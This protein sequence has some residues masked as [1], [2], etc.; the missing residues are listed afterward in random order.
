MRWNAHIEIGDP[1][2]LLY[3]DSIGG[4]YGFIL[5]RNEGVSLSVVARTN[6][7]SVKAN[8]AGPRLSTFYSIADVDLQGLRI[9]SENHGSHMV[10]IDHGKPAQSQS[11]KTF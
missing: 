5:G 1:L 9:E 11:L 2:T 3:H 8:V 7:E 10:Q 6:Y 4:F